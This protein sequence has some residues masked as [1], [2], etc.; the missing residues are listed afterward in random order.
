MENERTIRIFTNSL[1]SPETREKY[2][3]LVERFKK[4][5]HLKNYDSMISIPAEKLQIMV[6][7]YVM[8]LKNK[9]S[10]NTV[11]DY[12]WPIKAFF[13]SNDID[14]KWKKI[15]KLFPQRVKASGKLAWT[16]DEVRNM[17]KVAGKLRSIAI[18]SFLAASGCRVGGLVGLRLKHLIRIENSYAVIVYADDVEEYVTF[19]TPEATKALDDYLAERTKHG[20]HL[21][22]ES[23]VFREVYMIGSSKVEFATK[24]SL[25]GV[26]ERAIRKANLRGLKTGVRY[27]KQTD[28]AF[29]KRFITILK[30]NKDIPVAVA[31]KLCGHNAYKDEN[32]NNVMLDGSYMTPQLHQLFEHYKKA[33]S[34]LSIDDTAKLLAEKQKVEADKS[35]LEATIQQNL[36]LSAKVD[37]MEKRMNNMAIQYR[38]LVIKQ[39]KDETAKEQTVEKVKEQTTE[40][41]DPLY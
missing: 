8:E 34:D 11:P 25:T 38:Q 31:E 17:L 29:R 16:T 26:V 35:E 13:E 20:E 7:D 32:G 3:Y 9:L 12:Y 22:P 1:K 27:E 10:P 21:A 36:K 40:A 4:F 2:V 41:Q 19:L 33:I 18:I 30:L 39:Q 28:H 37:K 5:Y 15:E 14:L 23:P 24:K 6:E